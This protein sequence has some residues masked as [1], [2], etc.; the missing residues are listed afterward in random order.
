MSAFACQGPERNKYRLPTGTKSSLSPAKDKSTF[1]GKEA[2]RS[3]SWRWAWRDTLPGRTVAW[4]G[5]PIQS[6]P[7]KSSHTLS[8]S[9]PQ[10]ERWDRT[11]LPTCPSSGYEDQ[12]S[13]T[14]SKELLNAPKL[15]Y[16][17]PLRDS[18]SF[19]SIILHSSLSTTEPNSGMLM[20]VHFM[21]K[22]IRF[23]MSDCLEYRPKEYALLFSFPVLMPF[24]F[25]WSWEPL[26]KGMHETHE[27]KQMAR[28][29]TLLAGD[30]CL[31][32]Y[33]DDLVKT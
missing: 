14:L 8:L 20:K 24:L 30:F 7:W 11:A 4:A 29:R 1:R 25:I 32:F 16:T 19:F 28:H 15:W 12:V 9:F 22:V 31:A 26:V 3:D 27:T 23:W 10:E 21:Q 33:K 2:H 17:W 5:A 6:Q 18:Y 13:Y